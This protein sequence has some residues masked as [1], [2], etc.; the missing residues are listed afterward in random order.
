ME[1]Q[2]SYIGSNYSYIT[3]TQRA[4][5]TVRNVVS[6]DTQTI[7][8]FIRITI[9]KSTLRNSINKILKLQSKLNKIKSKNAK[10][11]K[12]ANYLEE[13]GLI[14]NKARYSSEIDIFKKKI[15]QLEILAAT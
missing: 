10:C 7:K 12:Y 5:K 14:L 6:V 2:T 11:K 13:R 4:N 8:A 3:F 15:E 9:S 1:K